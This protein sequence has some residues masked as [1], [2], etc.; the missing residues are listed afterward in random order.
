MFL[1]QESTAG[2]VSAGPRDILGKTQ[3]TNSLWR[4]NFSSYILHLQDHYH[5]VLASDQSHSLQNK[6]YFHISDDSLWFIFFSIYQFPWSDKLCNCI[7]SLNLS[8]IQQLN[9]GWG[10][11]ALQIN[12]DILLVQIIW[13]FSWSELFNLH[14]SFLQ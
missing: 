14:L 5:Y 11:C 10:Y 9:R 12:T 1:S 6:L 13:F 4:F 8:I 7:W 3:T 2:P